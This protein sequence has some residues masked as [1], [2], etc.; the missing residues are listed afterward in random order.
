M[1]FGLWTN[2]GALNS[3][4]VFD[5][6]R[7]GAKILGHDCVDNNE[8]SDVDVI[9]SVLFH[10]R[11]IGNKEIWRRAQEKNKP[12]IVLEVGGIQRGLTWKVGLG[13]INN[14][15][16]FG[17]KQNDSKRSKKFNLSL[18][19]WQLS[20]DDILIC[21][22]HN[23]SLQWKD[24]PD[25]RSWISQTIETLQ[26]YSNRRII[27]RP[28]PR[29]PVCGFSAKYQNVIEQNPVKQAGTYDNYHIDFS[30]IWATISWSSNP[31]VYSVIN[32]IPAIVGP[33]SLAW[34]VSEHSL[35]NIENP[36]MPERQ[37]W[38]NDYAWTEYTLEEISQGL[39]I[40]QLKTKLS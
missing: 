18:R 14:D 11:M 10:G 1:K 38:L 37:Q 33:S 25:I 21:G 29:C 3:K 22:Q 16:Y 36:R 26:K 4:P 23:K 9:W 2:Y 17:P 40:K 8:N 30:N 34:D 5:A 15:A 27:I 39:P 28:H 24:M 12:V 20:G 13:G 32:G 31:G 7:V 35:K 6:F 19:N